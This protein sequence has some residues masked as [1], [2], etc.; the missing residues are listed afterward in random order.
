M[1]ELWIIFFYYCIVIA[2]SVTL[3]GITRENKVVSVFGAIAMAVINGAVFYLGL[4][5]G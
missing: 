4:L 5:H 2:F 3:Y 1:I